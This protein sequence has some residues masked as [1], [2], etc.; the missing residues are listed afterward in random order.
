MEAYGATAV[1]LFFVPIFRSNHRHHHTNTTTSG[2]SLA[3]TSSVM[4][5]ST[6]LGPVSGSVHLILFWLVGWLVGWLLFV[7]FWL[8]EVVWCLCCFILIE[9]GVGFVEQVDIACCSVHLVWVCFVFFV[10]FLFCFVLFWLRWFYLGRVLWDGGDCG[11]PS[12]IYT[13]RHT[14]C[15]KHTQ[16]HNAPSYTL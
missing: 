2:S 1:F 8:G 13:R 14:R 6:T 12:I 5:R 10:F 3:L 15:M 4:M 9:G 11:R 16:I 7:W